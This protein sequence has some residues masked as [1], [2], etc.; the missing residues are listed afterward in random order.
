[1]R[2]T[3]NGTVDDYRGVYYEP[4]T[5]VAI[6]ETEYVEATATTSPISF[7]T[8]N[9][10]RYLDLSISVEGQPTSTQYTV[11]TCT[12]LDPDLSKWTAAAASRTASSAEI[13]AGALTLSVPST[14]DTQFVR[15][16]ASDHSIA[17]GTKLSALDL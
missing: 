4:V 2:Y 6:R 12:T 3:G 8:Q 14:S 7:R 10:T 15:I 5:I 16:V 1:M 11:F 17:K 9:G 13:A